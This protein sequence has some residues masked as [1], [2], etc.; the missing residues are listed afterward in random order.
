MKPG[1][2]GMMCVALAL[3]ASAVAQPPQEGRRP[4]GGGPFG[5]PPGMRGRF[6]NPLLDALDKDKNGELSEEEI[7]GAVAALKSLDRNKDRKLD[8]SELR[9][10]PQEMGRGGFG[11]FGG[12]GGPGGFGPG[13]PGGP[14]GQNGGGEA[15]LERMM[16]MDADQ[17]GKLSKSE[18]PERLQP[19]LERSDRNKDGALDREEVMAMARERMG[20]G[21][22]GPGQG[23]RPGE[24]LNRMMEASDADKNGKLT[25]EEIPPFLREQMAT[26]DANKDGELDKAELEAGMAARMREGFGGRGGEGRGEGRGG[27]GRGEGGGEGRGGEGRGGEGRGE[28]NEGERARPQRPPVEDAAPNPPA[29]DD[30][31]GG[32]RKER[33]DGNGDKE[34]SDKEDGDK[35]DGR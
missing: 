28:R 31:D 7:D 16:A 33:A 1:K 5:Q 4:E 30:A 8:G 3:S 24:F 9:P 29:G 34:D 18:L 35:E 15:M 17:D 23:P 32:D 11:G 13:G 14:G 19:M 25:G 21:Q 20:Q 12:P 6:P 26:F 22:P 27:E 10:M 2:L